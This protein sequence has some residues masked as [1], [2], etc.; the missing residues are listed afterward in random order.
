MTKRQLGVYYFVGFVCGLILVAAG[1]LVIVICLLA[2]GVI[3]IANYS[4]NYQCCYKT[5]RRYFIL[6]YHFI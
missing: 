5:N 1:I 3:I 6:H 4:G 2:V